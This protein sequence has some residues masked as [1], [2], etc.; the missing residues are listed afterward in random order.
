MPFSRTNN[1]FVG[2]TLL[3]TAFMT[4]G[5]VSIWIGAAIGFITLCSMYSTYV[6][7]TRQKLMQ[8]GFDLVYKSTASLAWEQTDGNTLT[9]DQQENRTATLNTLN[10]EVYWKQMIRFKQPE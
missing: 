1:L 8:N 3:G 10:D 5:I 2:I 9:P 6:V 4:I 7:R